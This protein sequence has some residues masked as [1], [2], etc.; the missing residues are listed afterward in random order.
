MSGDG[1]D[2]AA[3][4]A[5]AVEQRGRAFDDLD[6]VQA[7][8]IERLGVIARL[9]AQRAD[10]LAVLQYQNAIAVKAA[11]YGARR[12]RAEAALGDAQLK[13]ES[14]AERDG[15]LFSQLLRA[16][17][18]DRLDRV[19][20]SLLASRGGNCHLLA[21][22]RQLD[23]EI[24]RGHIARGDLNG[25][26]DVRGQVEMRRHVIPARQDVLEFVCPF[27]VG[28]DRA[29]Q[30]DDRHPHVVNGLFRVADRDH[31]AQRAIRLSKAT[32]GQGA[33]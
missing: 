20:C 9:K 12:A 23:L 1:V 7:E 28:L 26:H 22:R 18:R 29:F 6:S 32:H 8:Q 3:Y 19:E 31:A 17:D 15:V 24:G 27:L 2:H 16:D 11:D 13:I 33:Q 30:L 21:H 25:L 5:A 4:G 14:F 10:P